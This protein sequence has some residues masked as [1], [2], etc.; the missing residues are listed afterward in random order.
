MLRQFVRLFRPGL[1]LALGFGAAVAVAAPQDLQP[2]EYMKNAKFKAVY[3]KALGPKATTPW[4]V[5]M[6]GPAPPTRKVSVDGTEYVLGAICKNHDCGDNNAVWL[7][8][9]DKGLLYGTIFEKGQT[10]LVG[11]PPPAVAAQLPKLWKQEWRQ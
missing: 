11:A 5:K 8:Q 9:A 1:G 10:Q 7:Y 2:H 6:D 3:V 4:L